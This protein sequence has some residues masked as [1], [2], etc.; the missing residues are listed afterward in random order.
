[1]A[2]FKWKNPSSHS[3]DYQI[4]CI[5][6]LYFL[7]SIQ[8]WMGENTNIFETKSLTSN[9]NIYPIKIMKKYLHNNIFN[10]LLAGIRSREMQNKLRN[11]LPR[12]A[13]CYL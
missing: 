4:I 11:E 8:E 1:M 3:T 10:W 5:R 13:H 2:K 6:D 7:H 9:V 12:G